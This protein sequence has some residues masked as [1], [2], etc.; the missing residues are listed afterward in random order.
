MLTGW[1]SDGTNKYYMDPANGRMSVGSKDISGYYYFFNTSGHRQTG[2]VVLSGNYYYFDPKADGRMVAGE[3]KKIDGT[4]YEFGANGI[5]T[6]TV[7]VANAYDGTA[8][9]NVSHGTANSGTSNS[10]T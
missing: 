1:L 8:A 2:W 3:S 6:T 5:C 4:T 10:T 7:S 9:Q